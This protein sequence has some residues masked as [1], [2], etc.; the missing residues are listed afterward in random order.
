AD[1]TGDGNLDLATA[2]AWSDTVSIYLGDG[3]GGFTRMPDVPT[4]NG[5]NAPGAVPTD[6]PYGILAGNFD[7]DGTVDL[8]T[9]DIFSS[10]VT[11]LRGDGHGHFTLDALVPTGEAL[12][13]AVG[14]V[15]G[16]GLP[17]LIITNKETSDL[18]VVLAQGHGQ[19]REMTTTV[20]TGPVA[21][22]T[23]DL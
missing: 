14:D 16:D 3:Q 10:S 1:L 23:A 8:A 7:G 18:S 6:W 5:P 9:T 15:N 4:A 13:G 11:V 20:T 22:V 2:N 17:D 12:G 21:V 19:F